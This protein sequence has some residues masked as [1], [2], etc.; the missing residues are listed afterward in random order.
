VRPADTKPASWDDGTWDV[1]MRTDPPAS[2][3]SPAVSFYMNMRKKN[4]VFP[5]GA[6]CHPNNLNVKMYLQNREGISSHSCA[7]I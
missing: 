4:E 2:G 3:L 5:Q 6:A 1:G 7:L